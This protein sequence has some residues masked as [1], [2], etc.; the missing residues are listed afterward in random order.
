MCICVS[1]LNGKQLVR[2]VLKF[3]FSVSLNVI[4]GKS[5]SERCTLMGMNKEFNLSLNSLSLQYIKH[6]THKVIKKASGG[7][8][9]LSEGMF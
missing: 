4:Q 9:V 2:K 6:K 3:Q 7:V 8:Y 5:V 1:S